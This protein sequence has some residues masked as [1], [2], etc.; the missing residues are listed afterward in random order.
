MT[1]QCFLEQETLSIFFL[2]WL[3]TGSEIESELNKLHA[4]NTVGLKCSTIM[5]R[6]N[7]FVLLEVDGGK[8]AT[9]LIYNTV[10]LHDSVC[11]FENRTK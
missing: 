6:P 7:K 5:S 4:F 10:I 11:E 8:N 1:C 2:Y 3:V 9:N